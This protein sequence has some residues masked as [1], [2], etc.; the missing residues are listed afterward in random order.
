[1]RRNVRVRNKLLYHLIIMTMIF[2]DHGDQGKMEETDI[3]Q[4]QV[5]F[6]ENK[7]RKGEGGAT[8]CSTGGLLV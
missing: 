5:M 6:P 2:D 4:I 1:M 8:N 7:A 3:L